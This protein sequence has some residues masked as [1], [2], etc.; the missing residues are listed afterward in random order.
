MF[1]NEKNEQTEILHLHLLFLM[2]CSLPFIGRTEL[3]ELK[4]GICK[5]IFILYGTHVLRSWLRSRSP[6]RFRT[7][8]EGIMQISTLRWATPFNAMECIAS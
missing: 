4:T 7:L 8:C 2:D 5:I 6:A 1:I 3:S